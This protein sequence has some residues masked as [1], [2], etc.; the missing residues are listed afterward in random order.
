MQQEGENLKK[1]R[2]LHRYRDGVL[3]DAGRHGG[4]LQ[5]TWYW[6]QLLVGPLF[7]K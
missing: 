1:A 3:C 7:R 2:R 6:I 5:E 4:Q